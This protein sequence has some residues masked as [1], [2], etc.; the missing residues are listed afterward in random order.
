MFTTGREVAYLTLDGR[1]SALCSLDLA[2]A[3]LTAILHDRLLY[4]YQVSR[5]EWKH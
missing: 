5:S 1:V 4:A 3:T 2:G